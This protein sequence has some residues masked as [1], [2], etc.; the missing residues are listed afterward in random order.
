[1]GDYRPLVQDLS[2]AQHRVAGLLAESRGAADVAC[3]GDG[4]RAVGLHPLQV[5]DRTG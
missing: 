2:G 1:V 3:P 4:A 5:A